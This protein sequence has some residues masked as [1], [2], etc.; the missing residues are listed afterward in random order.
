MPRCAHCGKVNREGSLFCQDCGHRLEPAAPAPKPAAAAAGTTCSACGTVNPPGMNFC[1]MCGTSLAKVV[2]AAPAAAQPAFAATMAVDSGPIHVAPPQPVAAPA[3]A[4]VAAPAP[5]A[6]AQPSAPKA[7]CPACGKG[8]PVGFA[9]CQHC[10]Q[11][12]SASAPGAAARNAPAGAAAVPSSGP[13][14]APSQ[15]APVSHANT[16]AVAPGGVSPTP[17]AGMPRVQAAAATPAGAAPRAA[18]V[19]PGPGPTPGRHRSPRHKRAVP[20]AQAAGA[21]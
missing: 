12:L 11:R 17:P 15:P 10:G 9:F 16:I 5:A 8:T 13:V 2:V 7:I 19:A 3:P 18:H 1:K 20:P 4:P 6:A 21:G 14:A